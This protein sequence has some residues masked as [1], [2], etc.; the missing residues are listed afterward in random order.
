MD[1]YGYFTIYLGNNGKRPANN[2]LIYEP[3][4]TITIAIIYNNNDV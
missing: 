2:N 3:I 1:A 4:I